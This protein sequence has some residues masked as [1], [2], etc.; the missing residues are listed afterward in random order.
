[1]ATSA[2]NG[3]HEGEPG[4]ESQRVEVAHLETK[5]RGFRIRTPLPGRCMNV[6]S[7]DIRQGVWNIHTR[8]LE[9][10]ACWTKLIPAST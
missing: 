9:T 4:L 1:M 8:L 6:L 5:S 7:E 10:L 3:W 2:Q